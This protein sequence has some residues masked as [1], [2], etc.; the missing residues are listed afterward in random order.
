MLRNILCTM[1]TAHWGQLN[2]IVID[3]ITVID[4][5]WSARKRW[6]LVDWIALD[7]LNGFMF[8]LLLNAIDLRADLHGCNRGSGTRDRTDHTCS[9]Q[10]CPHTRQSAQTLIRDLGSLGGGSTKPFF[11]TKFPKKLHENQDISIMCV[12]FAAW[13]CGSFDVRVDVHDIIFSQLD[14]KIH[15]T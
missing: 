8:L 9:G 14:K 13:R 4:R 10:P 15:M 7:P 6:L 11:F 12:W 5:L 3:Y 1:R 2:P